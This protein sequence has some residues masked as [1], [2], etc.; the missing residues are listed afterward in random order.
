MPELNTL[1]ELTVFKDRKYKISSDVVLP[2][3]KGKLIDPALYYKSTAKEYR[4]N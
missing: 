4:N 2:A 3:I 1:E